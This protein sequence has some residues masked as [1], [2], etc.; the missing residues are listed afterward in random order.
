MHNPKTINGRMNMV[1]EYYDLN[2]NSASVRMNMANNSILGKILKDD[3]RKPSYNTILAFLNA[4]PKVNCEWLLLG[5][6]NMFGGKEESID[7]VS[8]RIAYLIHKFNLTTREFANKV[9]APHSE[10]VNILS[11][12][13]KPTVRLLSVIATEFKDVSPSWL[14][15]NEG[16]FYRDE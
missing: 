1:I 13:E 12:V 2:P 8:D 6:G 10:I 7:D 14:M 9:N 3:T 11:K 16:K 15:V 5:K 4:F